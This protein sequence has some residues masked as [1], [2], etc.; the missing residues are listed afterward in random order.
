MKSSG[1]VTAFTLLLLLSLFV[2][3]PSQGICKQDIQPV[4]TLLFSSP[5]T[6][7]TCEL[8]AAF[9][10]LAYAL[11]YTPDSI[12]YIVVYSG[13]NDLPGLFHR[14]SL[15]AKRVM[16]NEYKIAPDRVVI[17]SGGIRADFRA[18]YWIVPKGANPP[19]TGTFWQ[20]D[21]QR[22]EMG[23]FD[24]FYWGE[25]EYIYE[26]R[27][28]S[29]RLDGFAQALIKNP[30]TVGY[31]IGYAGGEKV[32]Y[33]Y[34]EGSEGKEKIVTRTF[35]L[36]GRKI[37]EWTK[38]SLVKELQVKP[39]QIVIIDGGYRQSGTVELWIVPAGG[40]APKPTPTIKK[41]NQ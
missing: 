36:K 39:S 11:T 7:A 17:I 23:K 35:K 2:A 14:H 20:P 10:E 8:T 21:I 15:G 16:V 13:R 25:S 29:T 24:E 4:P 3:F 37:A 5:S 6:G 33:A 28:S 26:Y 19:K 38:N 18:E 22:V 34:Q 9:S 41:R 31:L 40:D 1:F 27:N 30:D 32:T 12:G